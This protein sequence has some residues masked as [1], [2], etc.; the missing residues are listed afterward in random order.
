MNTASVCGQ[1]FLCLSHTSS[2]RE[3]VPASNRRGIH[4]GAVGEVSAQEFAD[5]DQLPGPRERLYQVPLLVDDKAE[6]PDGEDKA[7]FGVEEEV[8]TG[9]HRLHIPI[10]QD[11]L[12]EGAGDA[13][14]HLVLGLVDVRERGGQAG[15]DEDRAP[16]A[17]RSFSSCP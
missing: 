7:R 1:R 10:L 6:P 4:T 14:C 16:Q 17:T 5:V 2:I 3:S 9:D 12:V 8:T 11:G 13:Q 15:E